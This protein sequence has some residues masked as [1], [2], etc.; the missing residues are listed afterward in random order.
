MKPPVVLLVKSR[1]LSSKVTGITPPLGLLYIAAYL[2]KH[3]RAQV[4]VIDAAFEADPVESVLKSVK[5][6]SPGILGISSLTAESFLAH[7]ISRAV[8]T[9]CPPMPV[10]IGGPHP[11]SEPSWALEDKNI[12]A[13]VIGEGEETFYELVRLVH[14]EGENWKKSLNKIAGI[15]FIEDGRLN[16][17]GP[18]EP[19]QDLDSLPFPAWDII[20]YRRFWKRSGMATLGARPYF[21]IFISRGCPYQC[22][23]CHKLFGK[24]F[25]HRSPE[26]IADEI[27]GLLKLGAGHIEVLDDIAN[28][29]KEHFNSV[30]ETLLDRGLHPVLSFPNAIRADIMDKDSVDLLKKTGAG[31]VSVAVETASV[32]LQKLLKKNLNLQKTNET[33]D[34]L[35]KR[36]ILTRGFFMLG[37]P[38]ETEEEM[39]STIRFAHKSNLHI[40]LFFT[41]N[42]YRN[43]ELYDM[44]VKTGKMPKDFKSIDFEYY[45][46]PFNASEVPDN[47]YRRLYKWAYYGFYFNPAR[48]WRIARDRP[49]LSDIPMRVYSLLRN[50]ASFRRL[51]E[52][53]NQ[54]VK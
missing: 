10:I 30:L 11:S 4:R 49:V 33:I 42:P 47:L 35:A 2:K 21:T 46:A 37:F 48:A 9:A 20:D 22:V 31:E 29:K 45:G 34:L 6:L 27:S 40:A 36:R 51:N 15:A 26:N 18:R 38:T 8:K 24:T 1:S 13:A 7:R 17:T 23:F 5:E 50:V 44:F 14:E 39:R 53:N 52:S 12:D 3:F 32:R 16:V 28:F 41:P 19:I 25:R 54:S 43:T